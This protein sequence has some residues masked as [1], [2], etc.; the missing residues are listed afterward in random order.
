MHLSIVLAVAQAGLSSPVDAEQIVAP[1]ANGGERAHVPG[2]PLAGPATS[3]AAV[4]PRCQRLG[5]CRDVPRWPMQ[6]RG[7]GA[8]LR[9]SPPARRLSTLAPAAS[10]PGNMQTFWVTWFSHRRIIL[11]SDSDGQLIRHNCANAFVAMRIL[12]YIQQAVPGVIHIVV[13]PEFP[14]LLEVGTYY[15]ERMNRADPR[16]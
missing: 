1:L 12:L 6:A 8:G 9:S 4:P 13:F 5:C 10:Q 3:L 11:L 7:A 16:A 14:A 15:H 2:E